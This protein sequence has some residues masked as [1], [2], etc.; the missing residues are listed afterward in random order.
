MSFKPEIE[1]GG[2][3]WGRNALCFATEQEAMISARDVYSRWMLATNYRAVEVDEPVTH[4]LEQQENGEW[5]LSTV[6]ED[7]CSSDS[8]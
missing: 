1:V 7:A 4:K 8:K 2:K 3:E 6:K 5:M